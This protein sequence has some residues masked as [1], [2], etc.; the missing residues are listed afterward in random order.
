MKASGFI[1]A[2]DLIYITTSNGNLIICFART[3]KKKYIKKIAKSF[4]TG[5]IVS[6]RK[7]YLLSNDTK[8]FIFN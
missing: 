5:P 1:L 2:S 7:L 4:N 3:G 6:N 8:L